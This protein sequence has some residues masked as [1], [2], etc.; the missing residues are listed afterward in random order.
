M[1]R[2]VANLLMWVSRI[3]KASWR[4]DR[5]DVAAQPVAQEEFVAGEVRSVVALVEDEGLGVDSRDETFAGREQFLKLASHEVR[6][7]LCEI[8]SMRIGDTPCDRVEW[9]AAQG[10][11]GTGGVKLPR[12]AGGGD[13][14]PENGR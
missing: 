8:L 3:E 7:Q 13:E 6:R 10:P 4:A 2:T 5:A 14:V 1:Q 9:C 12:P 11:D